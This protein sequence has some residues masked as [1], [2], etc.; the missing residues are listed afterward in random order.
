MPTFASTIGTYAEKLPSGGTLKIS[1]TT[2]E[3]EYY[4]PGPDL[5]YNGVLLRIPGGRVE[6][7]I[8]ALQ[9]NWDEYQSLTTTIP[10]GG[11]F[12]KPGRENMVI[13]VGGP[14]DG[15]CLIS[16][17]GQMNSYSAIAKTVESYRYAIDRA[18]AM[19]SLLA[20]L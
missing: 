8:A 20:H 1:A 5:R 11:S 3:I 15:V 18:T 19:Q 6:S 4:F 17:E 14:F 2:W 16:C 7:F 9:Q 10:K 12:V 13:Y